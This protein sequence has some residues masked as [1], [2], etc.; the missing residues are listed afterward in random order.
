MMSPTDVQMHTLWKW[1]S[2]PAVMRFGVANN[3]PPA[4]SRPTR[5][6]SFSLEQLLVCARPATRNADLSLCNRAG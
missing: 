1:V 5:A 2:S 3:Y 4:W 6:R